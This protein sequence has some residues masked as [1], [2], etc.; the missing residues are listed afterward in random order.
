MRVLELGLDDARAPRSMPSRSAAAEGAGAGG[1]AWCCAGARGG[2]GAPR[3]T[4]CLAGPRSTWW[5]LGW[6]MRVGGGRWE[7][8]MGVGAMR[9]VSQPGKPEIDKI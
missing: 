5:R 3:W 7:V 2:A 4:C 6:E 9:A 8:A 1:G